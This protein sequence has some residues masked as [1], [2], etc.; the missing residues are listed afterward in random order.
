MKKRKRRNGLTLIELLVTI[1]AASILILTVGLILI[2]AFRS[3]R[4]NNVY[5]D[6]RRDSAFAFSMM[7][8]DVR[9][10]NY[11][12]LTDGNPLRLG[13]PVLGKADVT[14]TW[15]GTQLD[16]HD[17]SG[18]ITLLPANVSFFT[19]AGDD[20]GVLLT[21]VLSDEVYVG[22][23]TIAITNQVFVNTRN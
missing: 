10:A 14:Y 8:R 9:E 16:Y 18:T 20:D 1:A 21:L 15:S 6:L 12:T 2:M 22:G 3:L 13:S 23:Y 5:A 11:D 17:G 7:A 19:S 4:I